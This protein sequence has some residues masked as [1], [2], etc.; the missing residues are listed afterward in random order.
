MKEDNPQSATKTCSECGNPLGPGRSD[1][2]FCNDICRTA[3]NNRRR[4]DSIAEPVISYR[5]EAF[6]KIFKILTT[7]Q[8]MLMMYDIYKEPPYMFRDL[9]GKGF[10]P[11]YFTSE[12]LI[13]G[14]LFKFCFDYGYH[15]TE[16]GQ[17]YIEESS[18]EIFC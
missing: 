13:E 7:N 11:K 3:Y 15:V 2:K 4:G 10:N 14:L 5:Q 1:R 18:E 9:L 6:E 12:R 16:S 8:E 17:V